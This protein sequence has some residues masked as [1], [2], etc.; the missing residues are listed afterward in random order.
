MR[1][2]IYEILTNPRADDGVGRLISLALLGLIA[3]NVVASVLE[4]DAELA[5]AA[6]NFFHWFERV[7]IVVFTIEY[8]LRIWSC[9][10]DPR[11]AGPI[12]GRIRMAATPMALVDVVAILPFYV[13]LLLPGTVDLRFLRIL[14]LLR[15]FR[16]LRVS[17][18]ADAFAILI[19][20]LRSKRIELA[21][22]AA[23]VGVAVLVA[24][25]AMYVAERDEPGTLFTS[26]PRAMW[27]S[28]ITVTTIGYGDMVPTTAIGKVVGGLVAFIGIC[29]VAL[30]VGIISSGFIDELNR[31]K[32]ALPTCPHCGRALDG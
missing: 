26:I 13:E 21:V 23:V 20:V 3:A 31:K 14:R 1:R 8:A 22:S 18:I 15:V 7:S 2:R 16:L 17:R 6:P 32:P 11:F 12:R 19:R 5:R 25:G 24:A 28:V 30:P 10:S 9:T 27:W 29:A 4:T